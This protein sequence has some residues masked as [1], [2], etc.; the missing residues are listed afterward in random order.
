M[1]FSGKAFKKKG[2]RASRPKRSKAESFTGAKE[3]AVEV[4]SGELE[5][6]EPL[7]IPARDFN[8]S[9]NRMREINSKMATLK[10]AYSNELKR[11]GDI[12]EDM[13]P[14]LKLALAYDKK[15]P[16]QVIRHLQIHGYVLR[17]TGNDIQLTLHD[18]K[19]GDSKQVAY[20]EGF[21]IGAA[22]RGLPRE[23]KYP[24]NSELDNEFVRGHGDG[25]KRHL[26]IRE[27][28]NDPGVAAGPS[29]EFDEALE[30]EGATAA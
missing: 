24:I 5:L 10:S 13:P 11:A 26:P 1:G 8:T 18:L 20:Q 17:E 27:V 4:R 21:D 6:M 29:A 14:A 16:K 25:Q 12:D 23:S 15:S 2:T 7:H 19:M 30:E 22:G 9:L 28:A 3:N